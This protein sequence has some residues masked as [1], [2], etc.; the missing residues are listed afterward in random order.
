VN[1]PTRQV[2]FSRKNAWTLMPA[3]V[4]RAVG[5]L[6][7][8]VPQERLLGRNFRAARDFVNE[9]QWWPAD[10]ARDYQLERLQALCARAYDQSSHYRRVFEAAGFEPGDLRSLDDFRRLPFLDREEIRA[11]AEQL[12]TVSRLSPRLDV[13]STGGTS[14]VPLHFFIGS[15]RSDVEYAYLT[16]GWARAG[17]QLQQPMAIL[18]GDVIAP[19]RHGFRHDYDPVLRRHRYSTFHLS[20]ADIQRYLAHMATLGPCYLL[21]YPSVI[22]SIAR[23]VRK[24]GVA[25]PSNVRGIIVESEIVYPEQRAFAERTMGCRYFSLYGLTEKVVAAAECEHSSDYHVWPTYGFFE[26][27]DEAGRPITEPGQRGEIVGTSFLNSAM[28]FIRYRT[29]DFATYVGERCAGCRRE[30]SLIRDIRGHR[31][32][33]S[34]VAHDGS[35]IPWSA[36]NMHD[37]TFLRVMRFQFVQDTPGRSILRIVPGQGFS[38]ADRNRVLRNLGRKLEGRVE[39]TIEVVQSLPLS[40]RGKAI[41]VD[42][43]ITSVQDPD[44]RIA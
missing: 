38:P 35:L 13:V 36:L 37:D 26:L 28:P 5:S 4:R 32:Q 14:G 16:A 18:K 7:A 41:Y 2:A 10:R 12:L 40:A 21:A 30:H 24:T 42:Q 43:R 11:H 34:L 29:G 3:P 19:D 15:D 27:I 31:T 20:D 8:W 1:R 25:V 33:E 6:L 22:T 23:F 17:F 9:A 39:L 44:A